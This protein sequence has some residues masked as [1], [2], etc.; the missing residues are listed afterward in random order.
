MCDAVGLRMPRTLVLLL[1]LLRVLQDGGFQLV[2]DPVKV[3]FKPTAK[4]M[5]VAEE[6]GTDLA[7]AMLKS[8]RRE[9]RQA[10]S[11]Q[12]SG[13]PGFACTS[14]CC[15]GRA[16]RRSLLPFSNHAFVCIMPW[17][18]SFDTALLRCHEGCKSC[19]TH[20]PSCMQATRTL[21][22]A[23]ALLTSLRL[24]VLTGSASDTEQAV[25]RVLGSL[26]AITSRD[27]DAESAMLAS[28]ISQVQPPYTI[29][30]A[31]LDQPLSLTLVPSCPG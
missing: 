8:Q 1:K 22:E 21:H 6:S 19:A 5:Q 20:L 3:K 26:C 29:L 24:V 10:G 4:D 16:S 17:A 25:G 11:T 31:A 28:W 2:F 9:Q 23:A 18:Q 12:K 15:D 30:S 14:S 27:D 13:V 7:Q